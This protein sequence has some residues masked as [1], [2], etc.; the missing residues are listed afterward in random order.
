MNKFLLIL[1]MGFVLFPISFANGEVFDY[2]VYS[3]YT[4]VYKTIAWDAQSGA[5][6]YEFEVFSYDRQA[7]VLT[8]STVQTQINIIIPKAGLS[9]MRVRACDENECSEF[10]ESTDST[11]ATV[12]GQ[13]KGWIFHRKLAP[14][15]P[16]EIE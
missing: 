2:T 13:P 1:V 3:E 8:G 7:V 15:G 10:S 5:T 12:A 11:K 6:R 4:H 14:A 16:I 9:I